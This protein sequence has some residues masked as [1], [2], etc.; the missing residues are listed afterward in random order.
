MRT[1]RF[2]FT[3]AQLI[4]TALGAAVLIVIFQ[5]TFGLL[6]ATWQ[7]EEYSHGIL[8]PAISAYLLWQRRA[9]F[10]TLPFEGSWA[11]VGL[12]LLGLLVFFLGSFAA[13][14]T[15]DAYALVIVIA[16][17]MLAVM[18]WKAFRLALVPIALLLLMNPLPQFL[19]ANLSSYL[20]LVSSQIGVA[21]IRLFGISVYL[22]GNVIDLGTYQL[23][24]AEACSGLRYLFPLMSVGAIMAYLMNGKA[25]L[26]WTIFLS[27]VPLTI[28]M[29]SFRIGV[30]GLL[31]D[32]WGVE[33]ATG[34]IHLFEGWIVFMLC[35]VIL[36]F[37]A[38]GLVRLTGDKR[39][40][41]DL[42]VPDPPPAPAAEG[43][44]R[45]SR[46]IAASAIASLVLLVIA[47]YPARTLPEREELTPERASFVTFPMQ[48][49]KWHGRRQSIEQEYLEILKLDDYVQA[50]YFQDGK[51][52][53]NFYTAYYAS[54]RTGVSAHSPAS[55]LPGS[56]WRIESFERTSVPGARGG[57][58]PLMVNRVLIRHGSSRQLVYYWFQQRG[59]EVTNEYVVKWYLFWDSL[60]RSRSDGALVRLMT[61]LPRG[62]SIE[63]ADARLTEFSGQ[64]VSQLSQYVPN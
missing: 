32:R 41:R 64:V 47:V 9:Q 18:G 48:L 49:G 20:Q 61:P 12:V 37:E 19:Y 35:L 17:C 29:N 2:T 33:Q 36:S 53:V 13:I 44:S 55:C 1:T 60:T 22:E 15:V 7:L 24:V 21:V 16:G 59:R 39:R 11:G 28:L 52:A 30:I 14:T 27:T 58:T 38:W 25:W 26:R 31:V 8:I 5:S 34:F 10:A 4:G 56:G 3:R 45:Q 57:E 63:A 23:Q 62:E 40:F 51:P 43:T 50:N 42:F 54:Q 6:R 46:K